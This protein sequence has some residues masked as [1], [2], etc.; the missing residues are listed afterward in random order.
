[1]CKITPCSSVFIVNFEHVVNVSYGNNNLSF[2]RDTA[3]YYCFKRPAK[4]LGK[5]IKYDLINPLVPGVYLK[6]THT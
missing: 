3:D 4:Y 1:M 2:I 5:K 6:V